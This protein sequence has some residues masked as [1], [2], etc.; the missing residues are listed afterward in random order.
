MELLSIKIFYTICLIVLSFP[1]LLLLGAVTSGHP[2]G[3]ILGI[4]PFIF[5]VYLYIK[6]MY[7]ALK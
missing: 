7:K 5:C 1:L 2:A 3:V 4:V 6:C